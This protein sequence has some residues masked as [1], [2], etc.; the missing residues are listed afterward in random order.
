MSLAIRRCVYRQQPFESKRCFGNTGKPHRFRGRCK[1][2]LLL[3]KTSSERLIKALP[4]NSTSKL[5]CKLSPFTKTIFCRVNRRAKLTLRIA[6]GRNVTPARRFGCERSSAASGALR[7][8]CRRA[9][10]RSGVPITRSA[11]HRPL[12]IVLA[13]H[14]LSWGGG[15][16]HPG[17]F[18]SHPTEAAAARLNAACH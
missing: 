7:R 14:C 6:S 8:L 17:R 5:E 4:L 11:V 16:D 9:C 2:G 13:G 3:L 18:A 10:G 1:S 15:R 12:L